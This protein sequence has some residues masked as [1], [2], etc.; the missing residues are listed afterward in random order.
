MG[1][2]ELTFG[3]TL[4][5][6]GAGLLHAGWNAL[7]KSA[8]GGDPLLD[9]ATVVAGSGL[10]G[11]IVIPFVGIPDTA[12]WKFAA[13]SAL[14]HWGYYVTLAQAYRTGD[15][16]FAYPLMRGTAPLIVAVLGI[17]FLRELPA[18][19][20]AVGIALIC[21]GIVSIA[22]IRHQ[23]HPPS[24]AGWAFA[25]AAIIAAYTLV[26]GAGARASGNPPAY[27]SWLIFLE[28]LP[29]LAWIGVRRGRAALA[30]VRRD[31][32]R[33]VIGGAASLAAYGIV[34]W[35]MTH[36]P[37]AAVAALRETSVLFA[38]LIGAVW[39]KEGFGLPRLAGAASVVAGVAALKL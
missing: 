37:V 17:V 24:A 28:A 26:D 30:Y 15:L 7:L 21:G 3:V 27:V 25:N 32:G 34:L 36:A 10:W 4:A 1:E 5:V 38:A 31:W 12:S 2:T 22:F 39:L 8:P 23:R 11:L 29:F 14:I 35:A 6:L 16:S 9:T 13:V 20:V 19:H 33:G 18:P